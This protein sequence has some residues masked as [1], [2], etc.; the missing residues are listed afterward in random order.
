[1]RP[2]YVPAS[3]RA[4]LVGDTTYWSSGGAGSVVALVE[5]SR[6]RVDAL[7]AMRPRRALHVVVYATNAEAC[8]ALDRSLSPTALLAPLHTPDRALVALQSA[9][10]DPRNGDPARMIRHV[11]HEL[12]H[13][14]SYERTGSV[15]RLGDGDRGMRIAPWIDEGFAECVAIAAADRHDILEAAR[16]RAIEPAATDR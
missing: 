5:D 7:L 4:D 13:V 12:A 8:A 15:K 1:M 14:A 3:Y 9:E 2:E 6:A 11:C 16:V 10:A